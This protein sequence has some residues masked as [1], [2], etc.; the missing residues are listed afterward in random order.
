MRIL[1]RASPFALVEDDKGRQHC[2]WACPNRHAI[3]EVYLDDQTEEVVVDHCPH[4][5]NEALPD[6]FTTAL[7]QLIAQVA[8]STP[9]PI[10][11]GGGRDQD[12]IEA[13][14]TPVLL[15]G[16]D[17]YQPTNTL[18]ENPMDQING[19]VTTIATETQCED[20][21][22]TIV[23]TISHSVRDTV[24]NRAF[25]IGSAVGAV[26]AV[27]GVRVAQAYLAQAETS[28]DEPF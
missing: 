11:K 6:E 18:E 16:P 13:Q 12:I 19:S 9:V 27:V 20:E 8:S 23:K 15:P 24:R 22:G 14:Y 7:K 25:L 28:G 1:A 2:V 4:C 10:Q 5:G 17:H 26:L 3:V 21:R